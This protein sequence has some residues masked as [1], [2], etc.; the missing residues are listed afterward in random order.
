MRL[1]M[2]GRKIG[3]WEVV[4]AAEV[5]RGLQF[6]KCRCRCGYERQFS[7]SYLNTGL[8]SRCPE[9]RKSLRGTSE[10]EL[11]GRLVGKTFGKYTVIEL[12]GRNKYGTRQ[13]RC[14]CTCGQERLL[15]TSALS[16][17]GKWKASQCPACLRLEMEIHS[18]TL[19]VPPRFWQRFLGQAARRGVRVSVSQEEALALFRQQAGRCALSG[20]PLHFTQ[21]RTNFSRYTTASLDRI[22]SGKPYETGNIQWVHKKVNMMKGSLG[23]Q[24]FL[25]W[26]SR[27]ARGGNP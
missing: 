12:A 10:A 24:E 26:C 19:E 7:T 20:E 27:V 3:A 17:N 11:V 16:G 1:S 9:C 22:D 2:L 4:E 21:L 15:G 18:R 6:W 13:W 14:R 25:G 5:R 8:P 23:Q